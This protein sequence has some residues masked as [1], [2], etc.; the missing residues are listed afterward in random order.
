MASNRPGFQLVA[1]Q[2]EY[3]DAQ[4]QFVELAGGR[5]KMDKGQS[6]R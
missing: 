2:I 5:F 3:K 1:K 4:E 6:V